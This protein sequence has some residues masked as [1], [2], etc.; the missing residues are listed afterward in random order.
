[1]KN[2]KIIENRPEL[3]KEQLTQGMDFNKIKTNAAIAKTAI[4]KSLIIKC[5]LGIALTGSS[6][7][8]YK[9]TTS[10]V[11]ENN[12]VILKN[13]NKKTILITNSIS[14][15]LIDT[16]KQTKFVTKNNRPIT[17]K[18]ETQKV[19]SKQTLDS[20]LNNQKVFK[21]F[22][23]KRCV[24]LLPSHCCY[25]IPKSAKFATSVDSAGVEFNLIDCESIYHSKDVS[26]IWLTLTT[27]ENAYLKLEDQ[28][29]NF[30]LLKGKAKELHPFLIKVSSGPK[31][32]GSNFKG[33]T[34]TVKYNKQIDIL[35][36]YKN[37]DP[38]VGGKFRINKRIATINPTDNISQKTN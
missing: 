3:S 36:F 6:L 20:T 2:Y 7:L 13:E 16:S 18:E 30:A 32:W 24:I 9:L 37:A 31:L 38:Q 19:E 15:P 28:L 25:C 12:N 26:C 27:K 29:K 34:I 4:L 14:S 8:V 35:L 23:P 22:K 21:F 11:S 33:K 10:K 5:V 1:M 17:I